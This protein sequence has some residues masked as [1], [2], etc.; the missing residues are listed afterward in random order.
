MSRERERDLAARRDAVRRNRAKGVGR[1]LE[2]A[3]RLVRD[4]KAFHSGFRHRA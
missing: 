2:E 3:I 1:N 4:G